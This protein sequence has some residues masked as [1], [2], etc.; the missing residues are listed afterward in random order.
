MK[1]FKGG[2]VKK[3]NARWVLLKIDPD[4][5]L[6]E[7]YLGDP[8]TAHKLAEDSENFKRVGQ[9]GPRVLYEAF[10]ACIQ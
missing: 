4:Y 7:Y 9:A 1:G 6:R 5:R 3:Y 10:E 8:W 2:S